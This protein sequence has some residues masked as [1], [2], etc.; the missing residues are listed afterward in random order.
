MG[1]CWNI[2][3]YHF[4]HLKYLSKERLKVWNSRQDRN[5]VP[6]F[7]SIA[8]VCSRMEATPFAGF[9]GTLCIPQ[10]PHQQ[11]IPP[12]Q[13][14]EQFMLSSLSPSGEQLASISHRLC[15]L[16][17]AQCISV[18]ESAQAPTS[19]KENMSITRSWCCLR[20]NK[21]W[22]S[23]SGFGFNPR[24][25]EFQPWTLPTAFQATFPVMCRVSV[26]PGQ[27]EAPLY[28]RNQLRP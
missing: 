5:Y 15:C 28:P 6:S 19:G 16:L 7:S 8:T 13:K 20:S 2:K 26:N 9:R 11:E 4:I 12:Q 25:C 22:V 17:Q 23:R 18:S 21:R 10:P 14:T 27:G 1:I 24:C 3:T